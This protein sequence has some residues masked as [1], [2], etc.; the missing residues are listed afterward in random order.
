MKLETLITFFSTNPSAKLLRSNN[1]AHIIYF[2][3]QPFKV[4]GNLT[5]PH[6]QLQQRL[7]QYLDRVHEAE[8]DVLRDS[9]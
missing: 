3:N 2:L 4:D 5:T 9:A 1:A 7:D 8:P 6:S